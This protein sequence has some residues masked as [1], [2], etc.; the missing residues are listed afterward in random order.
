MPTVSPLAIVRLTCSTAR[1]TPWRVENSTV[2]ARTSSK[3]SAVMPASRAPLR[4]DDVAQAVAQGV[5]A[6]HRDHQ[7]RTR[8]K[9]DPPFS[10]HHEGGALGNHDA[11]LRGGRPH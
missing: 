1:T 8:K 2:R 11:P 3:G 4:I 5:E 10:R 9:G 6:E 7:R